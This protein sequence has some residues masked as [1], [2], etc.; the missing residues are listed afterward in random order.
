VLHGDGGAPNV[1][2][3]SAVCT[4]D[5]DC[6]TGNFCDPTK[7]ACADPVTYG[8]SAGPGTGG[9][10]NS[11][12][13]CQ[14]GFYLP[15]SCDSTSLDWSDSVDVSRDPQSLVESDTVVAADG[16]GTVVAAWST[17][18]YPETARLQSNQL[19]VSHDD[20]ASFHRLATPTN[21]PISATNDAVLAYDPGGGL[22][23]YVWEGF[24][25]GGFVG[26]QH[27]FVSTSSDGDNWSAAA[28]VDAPGDYQTGGTL[29]FPWISINPVNG[30][31]YVTYNATPMNTNGNE[32]LVVLASP[33]SPDA[34]AAGGDGGS[35]QSLSL[36]DGTRPNEA[37]DLARGAF[38]SAGDFYA[39]WME[40][41]AANAVVGGMLSGSPM[42]SV[43][44]TRIDL[45]AS[46]TPLTHNVQVSGTGEAVAWDGPTIA[47]APDGSAVY[48]SYLVGTNDAIDVV[49]AKSTDRGMTWSPSTKVNDD[50]PCATHFHSSLV[51]DAKGRLYVFWYD[52]RDG[53]G[54]FA[55]SVSD[56]GGKTFHRNRLVSAPAFPFDTFQY[57]T[58]W[59]GDYYEPA[60]AGGRLY[61]LW[62]DGR[63]DDQSHAFLAKATLP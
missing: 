61:L 1:P 7:L 38:D 12:A 13:G 63:E 56:D 10:S 62:S 51:L 49:V 28:Q 29:D 33:P 48:V 25:G 55:Y 21:G 37:P 54:H 52:N 40:D 42:I 46:L 59:L 50:A 27:V 45:G 17:I 15:T 60:L 44:F 14:S 34:G 32:R 9:H 53:S 31:A 30:H 24:G 8:Y 18:P 39:A 58:G 23:Y 11:G 36:S 5:Q 47:V 26:T 20:G 2:K 16:K 41:G 3:G 43:Y 4:R 57:S 35:A 6:P 22:W 19:A